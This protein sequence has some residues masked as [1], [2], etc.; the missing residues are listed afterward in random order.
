MAFSKFCLQTTKQQDDS[1]TMEK[2]FRELL[3]LKY[4][5]AFFSAQQKNKWFYA[6]L[7]NTVTGLR[8]GTIHPFQT[9]KSNFQR[10]SCSIL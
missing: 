6:F 2:Q 1:V 9:C 8:C 10:V 7:I 3:I 4:D 5:E